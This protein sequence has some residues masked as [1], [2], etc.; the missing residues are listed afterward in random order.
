MKAS[1]IFVLF[2]FSRLVLNAQIVNQDSLIKYPFKEDVEGRMKFEFDRLKDPKTGKIDFSQSEKIRGQVKLA[3]QNT[4]KTAIP[5]VQWTERGP[6]N[7]GGRTRTIVFDPNDPFKKK[8]WAGGVSGGLWYNNDITSS[9]SS[10]IKVNDFWEN[11]AISTIAFDPSNTQI[12]Y[13]GTGEYTNN[14]DR[15]IGGGIWKSADA[16]VTWQ[17][18]LSSIPSTPPFNTAQGNYVAKIV[19]NSTGKVFAATNSGLAFS[20]NGGNTWSIASN[21]S[22][23]NDLEIGS[24]NIVYFSSFNSLY[25]STDILGNN[26]VEITPKSIG[27]RTEFTLAKSTFGS[28]QIIY[29]TTYMHNSPVDLGYLSKSIDAGKTWIDLPIPTYPSGEHLTAGP[30]SNGQ[31]WYNLTLEVHP[32]NPNLLIMGGTNL[33]RT[34]DGGNTW[35]L[36]VDYWRIHPDQHIIAFRPNNLNEVIIGNDGGI[37]YSNNLGNINAKIISFEER[38]KNYNITQ[39]YSVAIRNI[40]GD[41]YI[42]GGTQDNFTQKITSAI[43]SIGAGKMILGGDG[44]LCFIDQ[45]EPNIQIASTQYNNFYLFDYSGNYISRLNTGLEPGE[46]INPADYD[47]QTNILYTYNGIGTINSNTV[48][49]IARVKNVGTTNTFDNIYM[50]D[51]LNVQSIKVCKSTPNAIF[52]TTLDKLFKISNLNTVT[53]TITSYNFP[54]EMTG[55]SLAIGQSDNE[56][57]V[58]STNAGTSTQKIIFSIDGG[59]TWI[60]KQENGY[61]L[62]SIPIFCALFNPL[63][64]SQVI[65][66]TEYGIWST[67]NINASNPNWG[68]S[69]NGLAN[70]RCEKLIYRESDGMIAVATHGRGIFM[71]DIFKKNIHWINLQFDK[72]FVCKN[73]TMPISFTHNLILGG[74]NLFNIEFSV[75]GDFSDAIVIGSSVSSTVSV[76][77]PN[78]QNSSQSCRLRVKATNPNIISNLSNKFEVNDEASVYL[79]PNKTVCPNESIVLEPSINVNK[80]DIDY[81]Q[82]TGPNN[83]TSSN[84]SVDI[85]IPNSLNIGT[86]YLTAKFKN[87]CSNTA[88]SS[89]N[90][91]LNS[92]PIISIMPIN[93]TFTIG[94]PSSLSFTGGNVYNIYGTN[95]ARFRISSPVNDLYFGVGNSGVYR[96]FGFSYNNGCYNSAS[97]LISLKTPCQ[98]NHNLSWQNVYTGNTKIQ[99]SGTILAE[100]RII[101]NAIMQ[102]SSGTSIELNPGFVVKPGAVFKASIDGCDN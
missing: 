21:V 6:N 92:L 95:W 3:L 20:I 33:S 102:Y 65:L 78:I 43:N 76:V 84:L 70:T 68:I 98:S 7:V 53:P 15:M 81:Y 51:W 18:L 1:L 40:A 9:S 44:G 82:W 28:N 24:D 60:S 91:T 23:L 29:I 8:V 10:W 45:D 85:S 48:T 63:N 94:Q 75:S 36:P 27:F 79:W 35:D 86:Y 30:S 56:L 80:D 58:T 71:S 4:I 39:F 12:I 2:F 69:N 13:V 96:V 47:S 74:N 67:D 11:L 101:N 90:I 55:S 41:G 89:T 59:A 99:S 19:V 31:G 42:L 87:V 50:P 37:Y 22:P 52:M 38:N 57:I 34:I 93:S 16:G 66:G 73:I 49:S 72:P 25:K 14:P 88:V 46:F 97:T 64:T 5:N 100:N 83:F 32:T 17:R 61:G 54:T 62:P 26:F 77:I